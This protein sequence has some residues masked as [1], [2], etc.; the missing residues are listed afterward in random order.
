MVAHL[1]NLF[2]SIRS[3]QDLESKLRELEHM[4]ES[5]KFSV[6]TNH[7]GD[8]L[9]VWAQNKMVVYD[10]EAPK[11]VFLSVVYGKLSEWRNVRLCDSK[12]IIPIS[13]KR[14]ILQV[15]EN[16]S[17]DNIKQWSLL[18][19]KATALQ[20]LECVNQLHWLYVAAYFPHLFTTSDV[21]RL[22]QS[23]G[24]T[25]TIDERDIENIIIPKVLDR[26]SNDDANRIFDEL[27]AVGKNARARDRLQELVDKVV[28]PQKGIFLPPSEDTVSNDKPRKGMGDGTSSFG[29]GG[30]GVDTTLAGTRTLP[31]N[32]VLCQNPSQVIHFNRLNV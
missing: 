12:I 25:C 3:Q 2:G 10:R 26:Y 18:A 28:K 1:N 6:L 27:P 20:L 8:E 4:W 30:S 32:A 24:K 11:V 23:L 22:Q 9:Q 5:Y 13:S 14:K 19:M 21:R 31:E 29:P 15:L 7:C 16:M 17:T